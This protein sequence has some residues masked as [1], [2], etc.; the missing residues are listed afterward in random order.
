MY[1]D[2]NENR[3]CE[4]YKFLRSKLKTDKLYNYKLITSYE[5]SLGCVN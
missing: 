5:V 2:I 1:V 4:I 3:Y